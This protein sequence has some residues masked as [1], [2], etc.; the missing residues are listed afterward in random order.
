MSPFRYHFAVRN[1]IVVGVSLRVG[2]PGLIAI[3]KTR[4]LDGI[5]RRR[6]CRYRHVRQGAQQIPGGFVGVD[7]VAGGSVSQDGSK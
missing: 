5:L 7:D 6:R 1:A 2:V 4:H 3:A